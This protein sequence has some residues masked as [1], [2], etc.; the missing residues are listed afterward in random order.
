MK[1][2]LPIALA[3][4]CAAICPSMAQNQLSTMSVDPAA[5]S[6]A[7]I[8]MR[9]KMDS[10][11]QYRP[12]VAVV[13]AGGGAKGAAHVGALEYIYELGIP[14]DMVLGTSMGGLMGGLIAMGYAPAIIDSVL[15]HTDWEVMMSD[16]IPDENLSFERKQYREKFLVNIAEFNLTVQQHYRM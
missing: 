16:R 15:V 6:C 8:K 14:V 2:I 5:D 7:I 11:R 3:C 12:T 1:K 9:H 10:I 13:L 4:L